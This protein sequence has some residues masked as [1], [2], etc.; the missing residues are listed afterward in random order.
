MANK[1]SNIIDTFPFL[2]EASA[3]EPFIFDVLNEIVSIQKKF[4]KGQK[5]SFATKEHIYTTRNIKMPFSPSREKNLSFVLDHLCAHF[6]E[7]ITSLIR[8]E[9]VV[10]EASKKIRVKEHLEYCYA[11]ANEEI[12]RLQADRDN[13]SVHSIENIVRRFRTFN[14]TRLMNMVQ[15]KKPFNAVLQKAINKTIFVYKS[16]EIKNNKF[17]P[18]Q[19]I[20]F[21]SKNYQAIKSNFSV[22]PFKSILTNYR[23]MINP[24]LSHY[25]IANTDVSDYTDKKIDYI[26]HIML[27]DL[28]SSITPKDMVQLHNFKSLRECIMRVD[29]ATDPTKVYHKE[30][31]EFVHENK[32]V[33]PSD[34]AAQLLSIDETTVRKWATP[35]NLKKEHILKHQESSTHVYLISAKNLQ[36]E[37]KTTYNL[38]RNN[39]DKVAAMTTSEREFHERKMQ[40]FLSVASH[41]VNQPDAHQIMNCQ[42]EDVGRLAELIEEYEDW[43]KQ[44][45]LR[46]ELSGDQMKKGGNIFASLIQIIFSIFSMFGSKGD[47]EED[48]AGSNSSRESASG[49]TQ[50]TQKKRPVTQRTRQ[51]YSKAK[52]H[53]GPILGLSEF[54]E[55]NKENDK[56]IDRLIDE[57]RS[58]NLKIIMPVYNARKALYPKRSSKLLIPDIEYLLIDPDV[59]KTSE[60]ITNYVDSLVG[61][62]MR[63]DVIPGNTL[64][65]IEKYLRNIHRQQ[66]ARLRNRK[67]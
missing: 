1:L 22:G 4:E 54:I 24:R 9:V 18:V 42:K 15:S 65:N 67:S 29:N 51:I 33:L 43:I 17:S 34:I 21:H 50:G 11:L 35:E 56:E 20:C 30:I 27:G 58:N 14:L 64:V 66:R 32:F 6:P 48:E 62:K 19:E 16:V 13:E 2:D 23:E 45:E 41:T 61:F 44:K 28:K 10:D 59:I 7:Y 63:D 36:A 37:F 26:L 49:S 57:M 52:A 46:N 47:G 31:V 25:G 5:R 3:K 8:F 60:A 55:L 12:D 40:I 38:F 39:S 53:R